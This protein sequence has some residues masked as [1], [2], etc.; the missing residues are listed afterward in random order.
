MAKAVNS[1][2]C[3]DGC[4]ILGTPCV[5]VGQRI[6]MKDGD[7]P[8]VEVGG[9]HAALC[10]KCLADAMSILCSHVY[11]NRLRSDKQSG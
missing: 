2:V 11:W 8:A 5:E 3:R 1:D 6:M 9:Q 7:E 4:N 10:L